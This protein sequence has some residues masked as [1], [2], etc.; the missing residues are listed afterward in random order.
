MH[1]IGAPLPRA[2][3]LP[4]PDLIDTTVLAAGLAALARKAGVAI[5]EVYRTGF[6]VT[7]K[8][9]R[10][11][12][13]LADQRSHEIIVEGL[14]RLTPGIP[15]LSEEGLAVPY[16]V[17]RAWGEFYLVDPLDGTKEF[18]NRN[19]EFTVNIALMRDA[20]PALGV[21]GVPARGLMYWGG[22][23]LGAWKMPEG[24]KAERIAMRPVADGGYTVVASRSHGSEALEAFLARIEVKERI[25]SGSA[26]KF[27][28]VA[29]GLADIYPRFG[30]TWEWDTAAGHAIIKGA[31]GVVTDM[32]GQSEIGYNKETPKH[33][34]FIVASS[35]T[36]AKLRPA[37]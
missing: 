27:C 4:A 30:P 19:G 31:G 10:S 17:R 14:S 35:A 20:A 34:G 16:D 33:A 7:Y 3:A 15:V 13:T 32:L 25:S 1:R 22:P 28:L 5:M 2:E 29:E 36:L 37:L 6:E 18:I 8:D 26:L 21:M 9:D 23:G 11:P 12:L 24:G